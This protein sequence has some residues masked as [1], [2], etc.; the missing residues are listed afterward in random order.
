MRKLIDGA[1]N[2]SYGI[3][4]ARLAGIPNEVLERAEQIL[5]T[6]EQ[7]GHQEFVQ[8]PEKPVAPSR[9]KQQ[10]N[11]FGDEPAPVTSDPRLQDLMHEL[12]NL[13]LDATTPIQALN[14]LYKWQKKLRQ[15]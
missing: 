5:E 14:W 11:L 3:Q 15:M 8:T 13:S 7:T 6:L 2:R 9:P 1:A 10:R 12:Q 4:V